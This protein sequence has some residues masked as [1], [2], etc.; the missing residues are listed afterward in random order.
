M[1]IA[2]KTIMILTMICLVALAS[3]C[4]N[5]ATPGQDGFQG[6]PLSVACPLLSRD[7]CLLRPGCFLDHLGEHVYR[8][9]TART[10]CEHVTNDGGQD[11]CESLEACAWDPGRCYCP[12]GLQCKCSGGPPRSCRERCAGFAGIPCPEGFFC[13]QPMDWPG[14]GYRACSGNYDQFG[15]C[16]LV[17]GDCTGMKERRVCGCL[18]EMSPN[19]PRTFANECTLRM[20][21]ASYSHPG[22][23]E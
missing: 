8:C 19:T 12:E 4:G 22:H 2:Q 14:P 6:E 15:S 9:R 13:S 5:D 7:A 23:C 21:K 1:K 17:P 10:D 20:A 11:R 18:S 3:A 16:L